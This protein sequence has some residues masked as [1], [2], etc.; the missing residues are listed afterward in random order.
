MPGS[1]LARDLPLFFAAREFGVAENSVTWRGAHVTGIFEDKD[2]EVANGEGVATIIRQPMF[3]SSSSQF[4][5]I[6]DGDA[7][8][9]GATAYV[10]KNWKDDGTGVIEIYLE[11]DSA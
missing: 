11:R 3:T 6:A 5:G 7:F 1:F 4:P 9:V 10:V 8:V 2:V